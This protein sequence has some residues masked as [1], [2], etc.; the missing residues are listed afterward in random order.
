MQ[1][2]TEQRPHKLS[3]NIDKSK[4][5]AVTKELSQRLEKRGV[6]LFCLIC[7]DN[8]FII[9]HNMFALF[10]RLMSNSFSV[11]EMLSMF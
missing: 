9:L 5:K 11:E 1:G 6:R 4:V 2:E 10:F 7:C 3:F 8:L